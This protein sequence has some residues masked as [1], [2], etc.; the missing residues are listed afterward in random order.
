MNENYGDYNPLN[1]PEQNDY[2][3]NVRMPQQCRAMHP[4]KPPLRCSLVLQAELPCK[5]VALGPRRLRTHST[6]GTS[7]LWRCRCQRGNRWS[8]VTFI[9]Q[10]RLADC[11][12]IHSLSTYTYL[13]AVAEAH[14][15]GQPW[16]EKE[17]TV[18]KGQRFVTAN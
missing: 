7:D 8:Q 15:N 17:E 5:V 13:L 1:Q 3:P 9:Q 18:G 12:H 2:P 6:L 4:S 10:P 14:I 11:T 16:S